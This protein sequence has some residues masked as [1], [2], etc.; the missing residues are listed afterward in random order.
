MGAKYVL[1]VLHVPENE[2]AGV[3]NGLCAHCLFAERIQSAKGSVFVLCG[4]SRS[5]PAFP[6]YPRLPVLQC[7]GY[8]CA[9]SQ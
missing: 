9:E 3:R 1:K 4:R 2:D 5:D 6:K 7:A 8:V